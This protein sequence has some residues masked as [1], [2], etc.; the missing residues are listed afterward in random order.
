VKAEW[1]LGGLAGRVPCLLV[2]AQAVVEDGGHP[3]RDD[4]HETL[5][6]GFGRLD[7]GVDQRDGLGLPAPQASELKGG[8][9]WH[10]DPDR[11]TDRVRFREQGSSLGE[12]A[13][14]RGEHGC[15]FQVDGQAVQG[16]RI[17]DDLDLPGGDRAIAVRV[18]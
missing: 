17:P 6:S 16:A 3:A 15:P 2:P 11:L 13:A 1:V 10:G 9:G 8:E 14:E 7:R 4:Q 18:P 12:V 5:A